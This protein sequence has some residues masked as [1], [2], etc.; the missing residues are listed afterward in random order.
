[1]NVK[2][3]LLAG[4][5]ALATT[6]GA[7]AYAATDGKPAPAGKEKASEMA[8]KPAEPAKKMATHHMAKRTVHRHK[9]LSH[10]HHKKAKPAES[11]A[12]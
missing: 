3:L 1:M 11:K 5:L 12:G 7:G 4:T 8:S 10:H 6:L 2:P 9:K